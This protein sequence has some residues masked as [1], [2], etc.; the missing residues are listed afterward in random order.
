M[1]AVEGLV[2]EFEAGYDM[3]LCTRTWCDSELSPLR[4]QAWLNRTRD[5]AFDFRDRS[6]ALAYFNAA[7]SLGGLFSF[8]SCIGFNRSRWLRTQPAA[9]VPCYTHVARLF[10]M[11]REG[12]PLRYI[13]APLVLCRG[14]TDSFRAGGMAGRLLLDLRGYRQL[15]DAL[16]NDDPAAKAA[17]LAVLRREHPLRRWF[18]ARLQTPDAAQWAEVESELRHYGLTLAPPLLVRNSRPAR[19]LL[20]L[21]RRAARAL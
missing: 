13:D 7:R 2:W 14:G 8:M 6:Q 11:A 16:F 9:A 20:G 18:D 10:R 19:K 3:V 15:A 5:A 21:L 12:A 4:A 17:F 1:G